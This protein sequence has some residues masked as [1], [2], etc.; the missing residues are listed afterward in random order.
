MFTPSGACP[1]DGVAKQAVARDV[2]RYILGADYTFPA[3]PFCAAAQ[4]SIDGIRQMMSNC[5]LTAPAGPSVVC[6]LQSAE[7]KLSCGLGVSG[8]L[9]G[10]TMNMTSQN[11]DMCFGAGV[12]TFFHTGTNTTEVWVTIDPEPTRAVQNL[13]GSTGATAAAVYVNSQTPTKI[14]KWP[15]SYTPGA[16]TAGSPCSVYDMVAGTNTL[17]TIQAY[18]GY[19]KCL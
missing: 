2:F 1:S 18:G 8:S 17:G 12:S 16:A 9:L 15:N 4:A 5:T 10:K 3:G 13:S 14:I 7:Y 11:L 19:R 6:G